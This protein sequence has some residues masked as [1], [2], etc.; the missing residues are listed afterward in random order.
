MNLSQFRH[1]K[2]ITGGENHLVH[3][4]TERLHDVV[5]K[6]K[7]IVLIRVVN[8]RHAKQPGTRQGTGHCR[9]QNGVSVIQRGIRR[10]PVPT[11]GKCFRFGE[12]LKIISCSHGFRI[13]GVSR[14]NR[15]RQH[16]QPSI[17]QA[18]ALQAFSLIGDLGLDRLPPETGFQRLGG[19]QL[20][21]R[22]PLRQRVPGKRLKHCRGHV[23][24]IADDNGNI[25]FRQCIETCRCHGKLQR[26]QNDETKIFQRKCPL[27]RSIVCISRF[28]SQQGMFEEQPAGRSEKQRPLQHDHLHSEDFISE[29]V[30]RRQ[31]T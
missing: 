26:L 23:R 20:R 19:P 28:I 9:P 15:F 22:M 18:Q 14:L 6:P 4:R 17:R 1:D 24:M 30:F 5:R 13:V 2:K 25:L 27:L 16:T 3:K 12:L 7:R 11:T 31:W 10:N 29:N 21:F 8:P